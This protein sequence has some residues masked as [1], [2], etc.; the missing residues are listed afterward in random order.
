MGE[1]RVDG[2]GPKK[3]VYMAKALRGRAFERKT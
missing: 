3:A 1:E 2:N